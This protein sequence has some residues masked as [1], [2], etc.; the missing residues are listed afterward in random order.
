MKPQWEWTTVVVTCAI[1]CAPSY[2]DVVTDWSAMFEQTVRE[3]GDFYLGS[4]GAVGRHGAIMFVSMYDAVNSITRT[5]EP[6]LG[7]TPCDPNTSLEAAATSAAFTVMMNLYP[8][9]LQ[10]SDYQALYAQHLSQI[11]DGPEKDAGIALGALC[12][13]AC[14]LAR[15]DDGSDKTVEYPAGDEPGEWVPT[16]PDYTGPWGANWCNVLPWAMTSGDQFRP[17]TGPFGYTDMASLLAS[18]EYAA[19]FLDVK[20]NGAIFSR[21]RTEDQSLAALFWANDR[22][23]TH[24]PP[25]HLLHITSVVAQGQA[26][27]LEENAR[28]FALVAIGMA[29]AG[30]AAWDAKYATDIDLWRPITA[31]WEGEND[32]NPATQGDPRWLG[33]SYDVSILI[34]TPPFPAWVSGH[35][36]FGAVH[37]AIMRKFY[38]TDDIAF[39]VTSDDTPGYWR[40]FTS[41]DQAAKEN[42]RSRIWLGVHYQMD[43]DGG[44][45]IGTALGDYVFQNF[46]RLLGDLDGDGVVDGADLG[47]LLAAWDEHGSEADLN[48]DGI[49]DG[50][51]LGVLLSNWS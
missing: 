9:P 30:I 25:G 10:T 50:A 26:N 2:G 44:Y 16:F 43:A 1:A 11:P 47:E 3:T 22:N 12:G 18:P 23:G 46:L 7:F 5:H 40:T 27:T 36:T 48:G 15:A 29:D 31:I 4:P 20:E 19:D 33:L 38:G 14:L 51:D 49:V 13:Q 37:A 35:A 45:E 42:G 32:G 17:A 21:T 39:T 28:L 41:F 34:F 6:Y 8:N 24:K